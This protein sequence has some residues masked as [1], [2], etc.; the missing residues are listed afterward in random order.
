MRNEINSNYH[1][2]QNPPFE[3]AQSIDHI[4]IFAVSQRTHNSRAGRDGALQKF[5]CPLIGQNKRLPDW[6]SRGAQLTHWLK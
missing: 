4:A 1:E 5:D 3:Q 6:L 2:S